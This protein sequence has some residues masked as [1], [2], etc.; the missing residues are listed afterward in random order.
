MPRRCTICSLPPEDLEQVNTLLV[1]GIPFRRI[2][3]HFGVSDRSLRRHRESHL[4]AE[5]VL[6]QRLRRLNAADGLVDRLLYLEQEAGRILEQCRVERPGSW[7]SRTAHRRTA[8]RA[9]A[10]LRRLAELREVER[11]LTEVEQ[12][13]AE[14]HESNVLQFRAGGGEE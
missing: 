4:P 3:P 7:Q 12:T 5:L 11:R 1:A 10:E 2:A 13:L 6:A 8:L 14:E 9:I